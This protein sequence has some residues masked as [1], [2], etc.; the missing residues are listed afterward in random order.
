MLIRVDLIERL[1]AAGCV[2]AEEEA[3]ALREVA[4]G[5]ALEDLVRRRVVGEPL[6]Y[7]VGNVSFGGRRYRLSPG[8]FIPRQRS[9]FLVEVAANLGGSTILDLCCGCGA[10]GLAVRDRIDPAVE[11]VGTDVSPDAVAN[12]RSNGVE[13]AFVGDLFDAVPMSLR[14][15]VDLLIANA[16]YVPSE[17]VARMPR[18]SREYEPLLS[19]DGGPDGLA[20]QRRILAQAPAWLSPTGSLLTETSRSQAAPLAALA[21]RAGLQAQVVRDEERGATVLIATLSR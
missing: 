19:V 1:R 17:E 6:E 12:A 10:L 7:L 21:R 9:T 18:E 8:V 20:V 3:V 13:E 2:F 11:L 15:R 5:T 4:T 14:G 16:P